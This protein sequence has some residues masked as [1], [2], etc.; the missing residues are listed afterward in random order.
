MS[1]GLAENIR[2]TK[3]AI[4]GDSDVKIIYHPHLSHCLFDGELKAPNNTGTRELFIGIHRRHYFDYNSGM[5]LRRLSSLATI[6]CKF[7]LIVVLE[8]T[9]FAGLVY[10]ARVALGYTNFEPAFFAFMALIVFVATAG[11]ITFF[12]LK[13]VRIDENYLYVS[14]YKKEITIP[15]SE[16][17]NVIQNGGLKLRSVTIRL[18]TPSEFGRNIVFLPHLNTLVSLSPHPVVEELFQTS[19]SKRL[20]EFSGPP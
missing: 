20:P 9:A 5:I 2:V 3:P 16:I 19:C 7:L 10:F 6:Y 4:A 14:N 17:A 15:I 1:T 18:R 12:Q 13:R 8:G 11:F